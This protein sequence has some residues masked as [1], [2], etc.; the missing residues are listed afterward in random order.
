MFANI[1]F[2]LIIHKNLICYIVKTNHT[3][4]VSFLYHKINIKLVLIRLA[5]Y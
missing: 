4:N 3:K 2:I 5:Y 1:A